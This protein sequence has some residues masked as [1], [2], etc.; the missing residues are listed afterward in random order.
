MKNK[1]FILYAASS[2]FFLNACTKKINEAYINPNANV[3]QPI[4]LL[5]P[6]V[7]SNMAVSYTANGTNYGLQNDNIYTGRY[8]QNWATNSAGN[9]YDG[10]GGATG[11]S[12]V[13]G[14]IWAM[15]YYGQGQN[16]N[17]II[18]W[19][20]EQKKW[21]YV[22][23][24][25]AI[26]AWSWLCLT[27]M[28]GDAIL[29]QAYNTSI[30]VF[31][32]D[33]QQEIYEEVKK[34][35][36]LAIENLNKTGD[37]VSQTNLAKGD[38]YFY[39]GDSEKWKKFTYSVMARVYHRTTNKADYKPD[40]VLYYA[41]LGINENADNGYVHFAGLGTSTNSFYG[42]FRGNIGTLRQTKFIADLQT[43]ENTNFPG[44]MDPRAWYILRTNPNG[45]FKGI[46]PTKGTDGLAVADR[47]QNFWGGEFAT[48]TGTN[49][50]AR[51]IFKDAVPFP[52]I[53]A[54]EIQFMKAEAYY[55]KNDKTNALVA[56]KKGISLSFDML[57]EQYSTSVSSANLI[58]E[59]SKNDYLNNPIIIPT[60]S[61]LTLSD[62][63]LQKY[64]ALYGYGVLETW[65]DMRRFHYIDL[66]KGTTRQVY[67]DFEP[68]AE[69]DLYVDNIKKPVYRARPRYNSEYLYNVDALKKI[70]A[71]E[72]NYHTN[73]MWFSDSK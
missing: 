25:H 12:D 9:Q 51:Y 36:R 56:Y 71:L 23:V 53:T 40:S 33:T 4:E 57:S 49:S 59:T 32:Y 37:S 10:M 18:E 35:C 68:P 47:P 50:N 30:L 31:N 15:H 22:G 5:L 6:N 58:T 16:L 27:D 1:H 61:E 63:M 2:I 54:A 38:K 26:R 65:V 52:I 39:N 21:D 41:N 67:T 29:K 3:V 11:G 73:E 69:S 28:Y 46:R 43:G 8:I 70:G 14:S 13:L 17:R 60:A 64:I 7:I 20:N 48:T 24:A 42:P 72:L 62:I 66:E 44:V 34:Q 19:G 45:S 55:R